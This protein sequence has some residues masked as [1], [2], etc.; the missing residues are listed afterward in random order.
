MKYQSPK[1]IFKLIPKL[2]RPYS[3]RNANNIPNFKVKY[4]FFKNTFFPSVNIKGNK[5]DTEIQNASGLKYFL[6]NILRFIGPAVN[7]IFSC[8]NLKSYDLHLVTFMNVN[9]K[10]TSKTHWIC[11]DFV[12]ATFKVQVTL[13]STVPIYSLREKHTLFNRITNIDSKF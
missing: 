2:T 12:A 10:I 7:N 6:K 5:L 1:Y 9:A 13:S 8:Q 4:G 3:K 11:F